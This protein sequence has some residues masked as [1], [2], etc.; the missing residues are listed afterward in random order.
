MMLPRNRYFSPLLARDRNESHR[1]ATQLELF[2]DLVV[3]IAI[4][5]AA[6]GLAHEI[7]EGQ[8]VMGLIKYL[9]AFFAIWWPWNLF[10][11]FAS[12]FDNDDEAY[13]INVMV[14]MAGVMLIAASIPT[15]F[16]DARMTYGFTG[17]IILRLASA[18][19]WLRVGGGNPQLKRTAKRYAVAQIAIQGFWAIVVFAAP[20]GSIAS[21]VLFA[22]GVVGE[23][24][25]PWYA[26]QATS[27][28][29]HRHHII[30]RFGL[31]TIIVLGE[32]MLGSTLALEE[33]ISHGF[34]GGL[35]AGAVCGMVL[36]FTMWWFYF[37]ESDHLESIEIKRAFVW[38]YGHFLVFASGA[39]VGAG[40]GLMSEVLAA[41]HGGEAH[42]SLQ[43]AGLAISIPLALYIV[44]LWLVRDRYQLKQPYG[45]LMLFFAVLIALSGFLPYPP[46][47]SMILMV[48]CLIVRLRSQVAFP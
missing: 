45:A 2:F 3:V 37:C 34:N 47:P 42:V 19:L 32:V 48:V 28:P 38:A 7:G 18:I 4:A 35:I 40:L 9:M 21:I 12:S 8:I 22:I 23:L 11:W 16:T 29:W 41:D 17:Y 30:E 46:L 5:A 25:I 31:L 6:H 26:E 15:I 10:T 36:A 24:F 33:G 39:A 43:T 27:T 14:M 44:S 13:R 1:T 20:P